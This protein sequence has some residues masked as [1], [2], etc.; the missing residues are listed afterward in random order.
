MAVHVVKRIAEAFPQL[1]LGV[2]ARRRD[3]A[4]VRVH[5]GK[6]QRRPRS[7][8]GRVLEFRRDGVNRHNRQ[9]VKLG[10]RV[11]GD[12]LLRHGQRAARGLG[13]I[14]RNHNLLVQHDRSFHSL[15]K[16]TAPTRRSDG[17]VNSVEPNLAGTSRKPGAGLTRT[18]HGPNTRLAHAQLELNSSPAQAQHV[19]GADL[20]RIRRTA[21]TNPT[22]A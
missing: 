5:I 17:G 14:E 8:A 6:H 19:P 7:G 1:L 16:P 10:R 20:A 9:N 13:S 12:E 22:Q 15:R 18:S 4:L 11:V 21:S 3:D 2:F